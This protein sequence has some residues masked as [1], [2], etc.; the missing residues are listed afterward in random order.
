MERPRRLV[1]G[2]ANVGGQA[3]VERAPGVGGDNGADLEDG[4]LDPN[5]D[6]GPVVGDPIPAPPQNQNRRRVR[7]D[8]LPSDSSDDNGQ[9]YDEQGDGEQPQ[10]DLEAAMRARVSSQGALQK[11]YVGFNVGEA[12]LLADTARVFSDVPEI[13]SGLPRTGGRPLENHLNAVRNLTIS[14]DA[15]VKNIRHKRLDAA[16]LKA[17]K[18]VATCAAAMAR[19]FLDSFHPISTAPGAVSALILFYEQPVHKCLLGCEL[20]AVIVNQLRSFSRVQRSLSAISFGSMCRWTA[21]H[22]HRSNRRSAGYGD[23]YGRDRGDRD[24]FRY[25]QSG[26]DGYGGRDGRG[27]RDAYGGRDRYEGDYGHG[28]VGHGGHRRGGPRRGRM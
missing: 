20:T 27:G 7:V 22:Q 14:W 21:R 13:I 25:G 9:D 16:A 19:Q 18:N 2:E 10:D 17:A 24:G 8:I 5:L 28:G 15:V 1:R 11:H 4:Q 6:L 3:E 12:V 26:R 23:N